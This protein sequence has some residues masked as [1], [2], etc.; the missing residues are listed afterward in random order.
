MESFGKFPLL[1]LLSLI[2]RLEKSSLLDCSS[3]LELGYLSRSLTE[4]EKLGKNARPIKTLIKTTTSVSGMPAFCARMK[5]RQD[6]WGVDRQCSGFL[7]Q[8]TGD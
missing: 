1:L 3:V 6:I 2:A 5:Q 7:N 4:N 8:W